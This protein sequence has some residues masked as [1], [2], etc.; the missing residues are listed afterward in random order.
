MK[1]G[2]DGEDPL[3]AVSLFSNCGAG[4]FGYRR[5]GFRF[6]VMAELQEKRLEVC[7]LNHPKAKGIKG[8]LRETW[9]QVVEEYKKR[10]HSFPLSLL[11]ACPPCQGMSSARGQ[12]GFHDDADAGSKDKRNLLAVVIAEVAMALE[13]KLIVVENVT[14]FLTKKVRHPDTNEPV[15]ASLLLIEK[16]KETYEVFPIV[17]DMCEFGIPQTRKRCF[18]TFVRKDQP[19]LKLLQK[20]GL[21]PYPKPWES[22][23]TTIVEALTSFGLKSLDASNAELAGKGLHSVPIWNTERYKMVAAIPPYSGKSAWQNN[24]CPNCQHEELDTV[25]V[26]CSMC[27]SLLPKPI[28]FEKNGT[29]RLIKGFRT[30]YK[31]IDANKP[32]STILTASSHTGSHNTIHPYENRLLSTLECAY[33]Q[34]MDDEFQWGDAPKKYGHSNIRE[35]I[36]EAVPPL[37]TEQHGKVLKDILRINLPITAIDNKDQRCKLALTK[38]SKAAKL[39]HTG[40]ENQLNMAI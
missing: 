6:E 31:R 37:F 2:K 24:T 4:D 34:T 33:L 25:A 18:L 29:P 14:E 21:A 13:P 11:A 22:P 23:P 27:K 17:L 10:S 28:V 9:P 36:G 32:S 8:D 30:S 19:A 1:H 15:T 3:Y 40:V 20:I 26:T 7:L 35:M 16:L 39:V 5:A 12:R 38:L